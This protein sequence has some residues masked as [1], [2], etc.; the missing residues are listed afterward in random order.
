MLVRKKLVVAIFLTSTASTSPGYSHPYYGYNLLTIPEPP[1][2]SAEPQ[3]TEDSARVTL[4]NN[5]F[6]MP[7]QSMKA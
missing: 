4:T 6:G 7:S 2:P 5:T 3:R 1:L